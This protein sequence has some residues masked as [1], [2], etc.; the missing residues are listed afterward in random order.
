M[1]AETAVLMSKA[2]FNRWMQDIERSGDRSR[3]HRYEWVAATLSD[4][5]R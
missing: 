1:T 3:P 4:G 5:L 2:E